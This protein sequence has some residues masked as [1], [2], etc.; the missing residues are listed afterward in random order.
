MPFDAGFGSYGVEESDAVIIC[1]D[2]LLVS[3]ASL[4]TR[5]TERDR[6]IEIEL[7]IEGRPLVREDPRERIRE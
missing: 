5:V 4:T 3:L 2:H 1:C 6:E 7:T